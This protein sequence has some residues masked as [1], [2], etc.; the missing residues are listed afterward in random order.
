MRNRKRLRRIRSAAASGGA[1]LELAV[2]LPLLV[3]I[4]LGCVD[5]GRA[6]YYSEVISAAA[7]N[8]AEYGATHR[9]NSYN[10]D[11]WAAEVYERVRREMATLPDFDETK[12]QMTIDNRV[13]DDGRIRV[14]IIVDY[15]FDLVVNWPG[16]PETIQMN[17]R[18][19]MR[20]Y[21]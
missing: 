11:S 9:F 8:G 4:A 18:V 15:P 10:Y 17:R 14:R 13:G 12:M 5:L 19:A 16:L 20:Q 7:R 21:R 6:A 2:V 3:L 1:A